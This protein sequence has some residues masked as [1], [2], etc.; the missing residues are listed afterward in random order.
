MAPPLINPL[1][2]GHPS[3]LLEKLIIDACSILDSR[4]DDIER[5]F[6]WDSVLLSLALRSN[7]K[8]HVLLRD[9]SA[10]AILISSNKL[11]RRGAIQMLKL[12]QLKQCPSNWNL[13]SAV[14][15]TRLPAL[16]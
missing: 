5:V 12:L 11:K 9:L 10:T 3:A 7:V 2:S 16:R 4:T 1:I 13:L 8:Y 15:S 14:Q 6:N